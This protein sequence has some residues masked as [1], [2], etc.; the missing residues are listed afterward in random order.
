MD[1]QND[2]R[3]SWVV[4]TL[5]WCCW[6]W[7]HRFLSLWNASIKQPCLTFLHPLCGWAP[8]SICW[9]RQPGTSQSS[10][11]CL[12]LFILFCF[13]VGGFFG[14]WACPLRVYWS[15]AVIRVTPHSR[16]LNARTRLQKQHIKPSNLFWKRNP[17]ARPE[18]LPC[19]GP[20]PR[21]SHSAHCQAPNWH[22]DIDPF[23]TTV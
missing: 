13:H 17:A 21:F 19:L 23:P 10:S 15:S 9:M 20:E 12:R 3:A 11:P 7:I 8:W 5:F 1:V 6:V 16:P 2:K 18:C 4:F 22:S 14:Y